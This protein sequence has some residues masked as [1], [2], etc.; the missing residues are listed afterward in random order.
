MPL[1]TTVVLSLFQ[2]ISLVTRYHG[3]ACSQTARPVRETDLWAVSSREAMKRYNDSK[4]QRK[5]GQTRKEENING[6]SDRDC[7]RG[8][9]DR[10]RM[11]HSPDEN[12]QSEIERILPRHLYIS[13][14]PIKLWNWIHGCGEREE[15]GERE[16]RGFGQQHAGCCCSGTEKEV[17][18]GM[19][20]H[21]SPLW[22][23]PSER[24]QLDGAQQ[25]NSD[26]ERHREEKHSEGGKKNTK[27][28]EWQ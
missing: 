17:R 20:K 16:R 24:H 21:S 2:N 23:L 1:R 18:S 8:T 5:S 28:R 3:H 6:S 12:R 22:H 14:K 11:W 27:G 19:T 26:R 9:L 4:R 10:V 13:L 7:N 25:P 15:E